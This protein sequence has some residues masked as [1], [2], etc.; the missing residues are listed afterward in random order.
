[1]YR[2]V[3]VDDEPFVLEDLRGAIDWEG[4]NFEITYADT[5]PVK[6]LSYIKSHPVD[7]LITDIS[8]PQ[9]NGLDLILQAKKSNPLLS[10]LV[11]S[12]YDNFEYV[13]TALRNGAEN[14]LLKPLNPDELLESVRSVTEHLKERSMISSTY[15]ATMLTF[16]SL[17]TENWVKGT[18]DTGDFLTRAELLGINL[19][20]NNYTVLLFSSPDED[21]QQ[22]SGLFDWLLSVCI[23]TFLS[24]F[25][26]ETPACLVCIL[27]SI[28]TPPDMEHF[29]NTLNQA[30]SL[31]PFSFFVSVGNTVDNY[32]D[33]SVSYRNAHSYLFLRHTSMKELNC[34]SML[35]PLSAHA[36]IE[37]NFT[38]VPEEDY[39]RQ[40]R[41]IL[42]PALDSRQRMAVMLTGIGHGLSQ[43]NFEQN[44]APKLLLLLKQIPCD[45]RHFHEISS[46]LYEFISTCYRILEQRRS[47]QSSRF[48]CIDTMIRAVHEFSN[49]ELSLKTLASQLDMHPSYLGNLFHQQTGYYF[50]DYLNEE[51]LKYAVEL[52]TQDKLKLKEIVDRTGFSS[53]TYFNRLFKRKYGLP[54]LVYRRE[55]K[56]KQIPGI[57]S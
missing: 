38:S 4:S 8:M 53:Q 26:F 15:G 55:M 14:Y 16:R 42:L 34:S 36:V 37:Q 12:A 1:M 22:M 30:R 28:H 10:V 13:R 5:D 45:G 57:D 3:I 31:F 19:S 27:S 56:A 24:H 11:L 20:L 48:P 21:A 39:I 18:L 23:G 7:L 49:K 52:M 47:V 33:V 40:L 25:Y 35:L 2:A 9:M 46:Y 17:F 41:T 54:P 6:V 50:N 51:R 43:T 44:Q 32:E 29:L